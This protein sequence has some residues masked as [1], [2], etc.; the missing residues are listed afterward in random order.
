VDR[1]FGCVRKRRFP[2]ERA[3]PIIQEVNVTTK[4]NRYCCRFG[5]LSFFFVI[6]NCMCDGWESGEDSTTEEGS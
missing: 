4:T 5:L 1:V 3:V 6:G 2:V